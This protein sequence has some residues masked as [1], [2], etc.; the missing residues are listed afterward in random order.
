MADQVLSPEDVERIVTYMNDARPEELVRYAEAYADV[1]DVEGARMT[2]IDADGFDL[3][4]ET[5]GATMPVR[6]EFDSPLNTVDEARS[7]LVDLAMAARNS[8]D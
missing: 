5:D 8:G 7:T 3:E 2:S 6:I 1:S 4:V